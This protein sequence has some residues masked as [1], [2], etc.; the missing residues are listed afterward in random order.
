MDAIDCD[1][2]VCGHS[3]IPFCRLLEGDKRGR[4]ARLWLNAGVI[5]MP[6][7]DGTARSWQLGSQSRAATFDC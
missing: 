7:N 5:G 4:G 3:G 1:G 6:A 2:V